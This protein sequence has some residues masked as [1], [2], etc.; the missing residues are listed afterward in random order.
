M[1][2][3]ALKIPNLIKCATDDSFLALFFGGKKEVS[4]TVYN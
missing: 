1:K 4:D 3:K 2:K